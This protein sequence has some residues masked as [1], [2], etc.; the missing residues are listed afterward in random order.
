DFNININGL[1]GKLPFDHNWVNESNINYVGPTPD[2][3]TYMKKEL[4]KLG[5]IQNG[6]FSFQRYC[7]VYNQIDCQGLYD[8]EG[9]GEMKNVFLY[10]NI[11]SQKKNKYF[12]K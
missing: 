5:V 7:Q 6:E 9:G 12:T 8:R 11:Y 10:I 3:L 4:I 2:W 1:T